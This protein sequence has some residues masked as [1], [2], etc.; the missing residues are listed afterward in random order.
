MRERVCDDEMCIR[1]SCKI[2]QMHLR[3]THLNTQKYLL[4]SLFSYFPVISYAINILFHKR[5]KYCTN[6][7]VNIFR[8]AK[9]WSIMSISTATRFVLTNDG[10]L[11]PVI[12]NAHVG[13]RVKTIL[14]LFID[15]FRCQTTLTASWSLFV[16]CAIN[17]V[18]VSRPNKTI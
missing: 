18:S 5:V 6:Y 17:T 4:A 10:H 8:A 9:P 12:S 7:T 13:R 11:Q 3:I 1:D 16:V 14:L 2:L 15:F